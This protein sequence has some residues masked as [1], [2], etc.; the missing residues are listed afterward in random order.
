MR[1]FVITAILVVLGLGGLYIY[2]SGLIESSSAKAATEGDTVSTDPAAGAEAPKGSQWATRCDEPKD[3]KPAHC[4]AFQSLTVTDTKQR[5]M[6]VAFAHP[7]DTM[8]T[9]VAIVMPLGIVV[10]AG[11]TLQAD[12]DPEG[13]KFQILTCVPEGCIARFNLDD[14]FMT[15]LKSAKTMTVGM[16]EA[17]G[18]PMNV[19]LSLEGFSDALAAIQK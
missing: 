16:A 12:E 10:S 9:A 14:A 11:G 8:E 13:K 5:F 6:E 18:K 2:K 17:S 19:K 7:K 1:V 4:E 15:K 3:G